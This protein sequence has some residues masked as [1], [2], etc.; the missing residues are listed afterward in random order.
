MKILIDECLPD[1]LN[2]GVVAMGHERQ[3]V[4]RAGY[5][6]KKNG[7]LLAKTLLTIQERICVPTARPI[8]GKASGD[9]A[10]PATNALVEI[11]AAGRNVGSWI[12]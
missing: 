10:V 3:T 6:S 9:V 12:T 5:G 4:R 7:E 2:E 1:E 11:I 8:P